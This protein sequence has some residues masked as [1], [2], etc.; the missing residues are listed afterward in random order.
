M[1]VVLLKD[2]KRLGKAG[3]VRNVADGYARNYLLPNGLAKPATAGAIREAQEQAES[4]ARR[5]ARELSQ[6]QTL[7][8]ALSG[9]SLTFRARAGTSGHLY[10][11]ITTADIAAEIQKQSGKTVDRRKI[12]LQEPIRSV[13]T[14]QVPIR[15]AGEVA[16]QVRVTVEP[17]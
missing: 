13:G 2:V 7:A 8:E 15:L 17:E 11:S 1:Q 10:G 16:A 4:Q 14:Y 5:A 9:L 12:V 6:A 3:E